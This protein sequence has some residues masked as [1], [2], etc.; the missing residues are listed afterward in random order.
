MAI[1]SGVFIAASPSPALAFLLIKIW[2]LKYAHLNMLMQSE[3]RQ[4]AWGDK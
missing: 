3:R 4:K 1:P 2:L